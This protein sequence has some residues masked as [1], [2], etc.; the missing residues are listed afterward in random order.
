MESNCTAFDVLPRDGAAMYRHVLGAPHCLGESRLA[1][2]LTSQGIV[3]TQ[4]PFMPSV[5]M[6]KLHDNDCYKDVRMEFQSPSF[7]CEKTCFDQF[8]MKP[9]SFE[10]LSAWLANKATLGGFQMGVNGKVIR[11]AEGPSFD[12]CTRDER[13]LK[14]T[15]N[16][17][18]WTTLALCRVLCKNTVAELLLQV[19]RQWQVQAAEGLQIAPHARLVSDGNDAWEQESFHIIFAQ[20]HMFMAKCGWESGSVHD[21]SRN[22][23]LVYFANAH[24]LTALMSYTYYNEI[25]TA[26]IVRGMSISGNA[27]WEEHVADA[28]FKRVS[29]DR[30]VQMI[31][32]HGRRF[33]GFSQQGVDGVD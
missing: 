18:D 22:G 9:V 19:R 31:K 1:Q 29:E 15:T 10:D 16:T 5:K 2:L 30:V 21:K 20:G 28:Q 13:D 3:C 14:F 24:M 11:V 8:V 23:P 4:V 6:N 25:Q 17:L 27:S 7:L 33:N 26:S 12:K 32:E